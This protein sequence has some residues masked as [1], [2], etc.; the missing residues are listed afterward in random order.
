MTMRYFIYESGETEGVYV[1]VCARD[2]VCVCVCVCACVCVCVCMRVCDYA[3]GAYG[4]VECNVA[5]GLEKA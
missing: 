4:C 3:G 2:C 1:Y 5:E